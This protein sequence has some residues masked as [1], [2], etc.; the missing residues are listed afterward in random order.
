[1]AEPQVA[2]NEFQ[3]SS[4][5]IPKDVFQAYG[6]AGDCDLIELK[7]PSAIRIQPQAYDPARYQ[8]EDPLQ[9]KNDVSQYNKRILSLCQTAFHSHEW[10]GDMSVDICQELCFDDKN[11][12]CRKA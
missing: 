7:L 11:V 1:M 12:K 6:R 4:R 3:L 5:L 2:Q 10:R 8:I 9:I